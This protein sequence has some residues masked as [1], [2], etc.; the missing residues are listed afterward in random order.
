MRNSKAELSRRS[1]LAGVGVA[2]AGAVAAAP[3]AYAATTTDLSATYAPT[4]GWFVVT[5]LQFAG[6]ATVGSADNKAAIDAAITAANA[7]GGGVVYFPAGTWK[8]S[9]AHIVYGNVWFVGAGK[10]TTTIQLANTSNTDLFKAQNFLTNTGGTGS[11]GP[12]HWGF[13]DLTLD[14]NGAGQ[15]AACWPLRVFGRSYTLQGVD[16]INGYSGCF[17]TEW[18]N[19]GSD[20]ES[21]VINCKFHD[22]LAGDTVNNYGPHDSKWSHSMIYHCGSVTPGRGLVLG[23]NAGVGQNGA[24]GTVHTDVHLFGYGTTGVE[25]GCPAQ[26]EN[27]ISE[28]FT[29]DVFFNTASNGSA[30]HGGMIFG[31]NGSG[32]TG[33]TTA[34]GVT[35][36]TL[37]NP[38]MFNFGKGSWIFNFGNGGRN[39]YKAQVKLASATIWSG[40]GYVGATDYVDL[41]VMDAAATSVNSMPF[42]PTYRSGFTV[43]AGTVAI[44]NSSTDQFSV[45]PS[46]GRVGLPNNAF[47]ALYKDNYVTKTAGLD[48]ATGYIQPG[49]AAGVG[50]HI[51]SG[52]GAPT[53]SATTGDFYFRLDTGLTANQRLYVCT[54][55]TNWTGIL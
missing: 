10:A 27:C 51:Y 18:G 2:I 43:T 14:G 28:G 49:T 32:E 38:Y 44:K 36:V 21:L 22:N 8:T 39:F 13:Q 17:W 35:N 30:W 1:V 45:V 23:T 25:V 42:G 31:T 20:M 11:G 24:N 37:D 29:T 47:L 16:I 7:A 34:A 40:A 12:A 53:I 46:T 33:F 26:F 19:G 6:G 54:G 48:G 15:T 50:S 41:F 9:G 5:D 4:V 52:S 55:T 3:P